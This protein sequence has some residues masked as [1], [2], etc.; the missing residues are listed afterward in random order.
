MKN[1]GVLLLAALGTAGAMADDSNSYS[2]EVASIATQDSE[3]T[4]EYVEALKFRSNTMDL[5]KQLQEANDE[6]NRQLEIRLQERFSKA[7]S[8]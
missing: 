8:I 7:L 6:I 1:L 3:R 2:F 4:Q 5:E